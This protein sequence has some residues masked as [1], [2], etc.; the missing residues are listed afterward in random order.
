MSNFNVYLRF[1]FFFTISSFSLDPAIEIYFAW[2]ADFYYGYIIRLTKKW[3][4]KIVAFSS[5]SIS[6]SYPLRNIYKNFLS[7]VLFHKGKKLSNFTIFGNKREK[8]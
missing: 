2:A 1:L 8:F 4:T 7:I 5:H 3:E 6:L